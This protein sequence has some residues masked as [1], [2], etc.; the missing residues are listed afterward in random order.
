M[1][2]QRPF[3]LRC[4]ECGDSKIVSPKSDVINAAEM[5]SFCSKCKVFMKRESLSG[6]FKILD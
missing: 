5:V 3:I 4:P 2:K 1:I 6:L